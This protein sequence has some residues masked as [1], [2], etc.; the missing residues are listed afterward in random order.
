MSFTHLHIHNNV[1]S[2]LDG[3]ASLEDYAKR[4]VELGHTHLACTDHGSLSGWYDLQQACTKYKLQ[5]IFG[6]EQYVIEEKEM[7]EINSEKKRRRYPNQHLILLAKNEAG[8]KNISHLHYDSMTL[9]GR[10]YYRNHS[11]IEDIFKYSEG[12]MVGTACMASPFAR[13]LKEG[14]PEEAEKLFL[15]FKDVFKDDFYVELQFNELNDDRIGGL[16]N[17]QK[18]INNFMKGLADKHNVKKVITGDV[19]YLNQEDNVVQNIA[20]AMRSGFTKA[21][22][23]DETK[24]TFQIESKN[25]FYHDVSDYKDFNKRWDYGY[26]DEEIEEW[27]NNSQY[28]ADKCDYQIPERDHMII[29][30]VTAD[31]ITKLNDECYLGLEKKIKEG[32]IEE[33]DREKY[34]KRLEYEKGILVKKGFAS[35]VLVLWDIF[36]FCSDNKFMVGFGRGC[37]LPNNKVQMA[38]GS[39]KNIQEIKMGDYITSGCAKEEIVKNVYE[40]DID[41]E[42][43]ELTTEDGRVISCTKDHKILKVDKNKREY[44]SEKKYSVKLSNSWVEAS[45]LEVGDIL[46]DINLKEIYNNNKIMKKEFKKYKG[47]VYDLNINSLDHTYNIEGLSVHNSGAG[48][49]V[50]YLLNITKIDPVKLDLIFERFLSESRSPD[51]VM[52]YFKELD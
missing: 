9:E 5:P 11:T 8:Y 44:E 43:V 17:G 18:T 22:I 6:L 52:S 25:L 40:Y 15:K 32:L 10:Y 38:D 19:H 26:T 41:E 42:I 12:V 49:L 14:K 29:P 23:E 24:K 48:S 28:F 47:K 35:Y 20:I 2:K 45:K 21:D 37:F 36:K 33:K 46:V 1:G 31:D 27:C 30:A 13:L 50:L 7:L 34:V 16:E 51:V 4:A 3:I 39:L